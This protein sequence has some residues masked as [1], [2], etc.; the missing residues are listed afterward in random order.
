LHG[1][2]NSYFT[3]III[4]SLSSLQSNFLLIEKILWPAIFIVLNFE[5]HN[6]CW[7]AIN[8]INLKTA[9]L[10]KRDIINYAF[11]Y[12]H[13]QSYNF[14]Q[15][16]LSGSISN[17]IIILAD[18][19]EKISS[20]ISIRIIRGLVQLLVALISMYFVHPIFSIV[21]LVWAMSFIFASLIYSKKITAF[22]NDYAKSQSDVSGKIV[23]NIVNFSNVK[24]FARN[25]FESFELQK[26][27]NIMRQKFQ[28]KEWFLIKFYFVQGL[29]ITFFIGAMVCFLILL[30]MNDQV[31]IGDFAFILSLSF[32]LTEN[33]WAFTEQIDQTND[34]IGKCNQSLK[35]LF[36]PIEITDKKTAKPLLISSGK[37]TFENV[38]FNYKN[39]EPLFK[40][41]SILI[42]SGQKVAL[43]GYSGVGKSTFINLLLR[44]YDV[45]SGCITIDEQ[46]IR[47]V[48]Q[49]SLRNA[50][51]IIPQD[52]I[53]FHRSLMENIR[54]GRVD[55]TDEEVIESSKQ[56]NMHDFI[57]K[58][59][60]GYKTLVGERGVKLSGGQR[61]RIA[62]ARAMLKNAPILILDEA[63]S[64]L[65]YVT[66]NT[67]KESL[68]Y[69]MEGKTTIVIAHRLS[70]LLH[71]DRILV[72]NHGKIVEDG[73]HKEL[74][75]RKGIYKKLW[76]AQ[77]AGVL[78]NDNK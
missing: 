67:I 29:S 64:Q 66:E 72:F 19:I 35:M 27:L 33:V 17:N 39:T 41:K 42:T 43:V 28:G 62:I 21:L 8:F 54:Y 76:N 58:L 49:E 44:L 56:A 26:T 78:L 9:P 38:C 48:T 68:S 36:I 32:Y 15:D 23:D 52:P 5:F 50:I 16:N 20:V 25:K 69:L 74:L 14:F 40:N 45:T 22:S 11:N 53:L 4:D 24:I 3:K 55:A 1:L 30:R 60:N 31:T 57:T 6:V 13:D 70:T 77:I 75:K 51:A 18:N 65:D 59:P 61:Q 73:S 47:E 46:D 71:M 12:V 7:R 2:I 34:A 10:I 37:I 63:T